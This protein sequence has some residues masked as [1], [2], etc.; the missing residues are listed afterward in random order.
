MPNI[1]DRLKPWYNH[2]MKVR[3]QN[4]DKTLKEAMIL[5]KKTYRK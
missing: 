3:A 5:A 2:L 1:P 4:P